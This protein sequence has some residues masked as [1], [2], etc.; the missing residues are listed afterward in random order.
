MVAVR[1]GEIA[2]AASMI[3]QALVLAGADESVKFAAVLDDVG[4]TPVD[5]IV[6]L[7]LGLVPS[8]VRLS[9]GVALVLLPLN[10]VLARSQSRDLELA[11]HE[12]GGV[13][14]EPGVPLLPDTH[15]PNLVPVELARVSGADGRGK[16][17][18]VDAIVTDKVTDLIVAGQCKIEDVQS[19]VFLDDI[20]VAQFVRVDSFGEVH[21]S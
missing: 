20:K 16:R 10:Q 2:R 6:T 11:L 13:E 4:V 7:L 15:R 21:P 8:R 14:Q 19:P 9:H 1:A 17:L 3:E 5:P 18:P 12:I